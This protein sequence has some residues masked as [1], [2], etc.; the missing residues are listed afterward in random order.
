MKDEV[1][2]LSDSFLSDNPPFVSMLQQSPTSVNTLPAEEIAPAITLPPESLQLRDWMPPIVST[3]VTHLMVPVKH[4]DS[5]Y[6]ATGSKTLLNKL[7]K[8][9]GS[10][11]CYCFTLTAQDPAYIAR[12]RFLKP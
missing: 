4:T 9:Y 7:S 6:N 5:L 11:G 12:I 10:E 3:E 8:K 1:M 2:P